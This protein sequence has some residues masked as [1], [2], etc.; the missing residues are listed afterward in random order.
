M[1]LRELRAIPERGEQLQ[2]KTRVVSKCVTTRGGGSRLAD[3]LQLLLADARLRIAGLPLG[4]H[5]MAAAASSERRLRSTSAARRSKLTSPIPQ[6]ARRG[7]RGRKRGSRQAAHR[8]HAARRDGRGV[9]GWGFEG[10]AAQPAER[11]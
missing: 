8:Q 6:C 3:L 10:A 11:R 7:R 4:C 5:G 9:S 1:P 2:D